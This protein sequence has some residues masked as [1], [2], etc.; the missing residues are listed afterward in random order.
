MSKELGDFQTNQDFAEVV[1][2]LLKRNGVNPSIV[3][4]PTCGEGNFIIASLKNFENI[5]KVIGIEIQ[6]K[7]TLRT[8]DK[9]RV[10]KKDN[11]INLPEISIVQ[12]NIFLYD[13]NEVTF[14]KNSELLLI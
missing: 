9:M 8:K 2:R 14:E 6:E 7:Y 1:C 13:F 4:E 3:I 10:F 12:D 5:K 11:K